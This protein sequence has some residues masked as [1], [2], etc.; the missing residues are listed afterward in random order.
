MVMLAGEEAPATAA[1]PAERDADSEDDSGKR[2][3]KKLQ[4]AADPNDTPE[5]RRRRKELAA[6]DED[7]KIESDKAVP[8]RT[9][10]TVRQQDK[11]TPGEV[12]QVG[13]FLRW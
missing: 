12:Q 9:F 13:F 2:T 4:V 6:K 11:D 3:S 7:E 1:A 10:D 8:L 5:M